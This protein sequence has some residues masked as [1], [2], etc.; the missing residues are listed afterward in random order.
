MIFYKVYERFIWWIIELPMPI[1]TG[2]LIALILIWL[3]FGKSVA[4][5]ILMI[6]LGLVPAWAVLH[7]VFWLSDSYPIFKI[8][9]YPG[10]AAVDIMIVWAIVY[11]VRAFLPDRRNRE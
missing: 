5:A 2:A 1:F 4:G 7:F 11:V 10:A 9:A 3:I 6:T 8:V